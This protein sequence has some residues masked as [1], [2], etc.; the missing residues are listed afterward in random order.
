MAQALH[1]FRKDV[2]ALRAHIGI[3]LALLAG[4]TWAHIRL[5]LTRRPTFDFRG[6]VAYYSGVFLV[7]AW[8]VLISELI[9]EEA[10]P[11]QRQF[12]ITRPYSWRQLLAAKVLFVL[13]F[14]NAPLLA[15]QMLLL[16]VSGFS[17]IDALPKLL[18]LQFAAILFLLA[19]V[20]AVAA[21]TR[22][23]LQF[24]LTVL[25]AVVAFFYG[26]DA[27][28]SIDLSGGAWLNNGVAVVIL[29]VGAVPIVLWQYARRSTGASVVAVTVTA[30][31]AL[32]ACAGIPATAQAA[33]QTRIFRQPETRN[34]RAFVQ[35]WVWAT[36]SYRSEGPMVRVEIPIAFANVPKGEYANLSMVNFTIDSPRGLHWSSG[37]EQQGFSPFYD[38]VLP[39]REYGRVQNSRATVKG[40]MFV[41]VSKQTTRPLQRGAVMRLPGGAVCEAGPTADDWVFC[42]SAFR[43]PYRSADETVIVAPKWVSPWPAEFSLDP[44]YIGISH[45]PSG[46]GSYVIE[47]DTRAWIR[48]DFVAHN[49]QFP[50]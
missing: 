16:A 50:L 37:W 22:N 2:R 6:T 13:A 10:L 42:K 18:W 34:I 48:S 29:C 9:R 15:A 40:S 43:P 46:P 45:A 14:V 4:F 38:L 47:E 39:R 11:G 20:F 44:V 17:P 19:P 32:A 12:W 8:W 31:A 25:A 24:V 35:D 30:V 36:P 7:F 49:V 5:D 41:V 33:L 26:A 1:I 3:V 21:V 23:L 27:F 28:L